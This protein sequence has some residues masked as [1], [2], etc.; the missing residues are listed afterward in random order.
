MNQRFIMLVGLSGSGKSVYAESLNKAYDNSVVIESD[1]Y[2]E[3][4]YGDASVQGDNNKLFGK[5]HADILSNLAEG[6]TVIFDATNLIRKN[7]MSLMN[8]LPKNLEKGCVIIATEYSKCLEQNQKRERQV[9]IYVIDRMYKSFQVPTFSEGW[10]WIYVEYNYEKENYSIE[11]YLSFADTYNQDNHH[12]SLTL[13]QHSRKVGE[14]LKDKK[15]DEHVYLAGLLHD[16]GKPM[17]KVFTNMKGE[18]SEIAHYYGH[19]NCG[20]YE[21]MFYLNDLIVRTNDFIEAVSLINYHMRLYMAKSEKALSK[22][23][24]IM[25][26]SYFYLELLH[27]ADVKAH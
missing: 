24:D 27:D 1:A 10:N 21:A 6:K 19:E 8:A 26:D 20:A 5:I 2:R 18:P 15:V 4:E 16:C 17:T 22:I 7:R 14:I 13:G 9:P 11:K 12:H 3:K 23:I 25:G